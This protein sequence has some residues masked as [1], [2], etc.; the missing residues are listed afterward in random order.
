MSASAK[1]AVIVLSAIVFIASLG[2]LVWLRRSIA[3]ID[4]KIAQSAAHRVALESSLA[5]GKA[6]L[7]S[8]ERSL[9]QAAQSATAPRAEGA[10]ANRRAAFNLWE[11]LE[12][13]PK[14]M[15]LYLRDFRAN[16]LD[17]FGPL[18]VQ[19]TITPEQISKWEDLATA[20]E[21]ENIDLRAAAA[22]QGLPADD[23]GIAA[24][25]R[26][27]N[28]Q[29]REASIAIVGEGV[30]QQVQSY[31]APPNGMVQFIN[32]MAASAAQNG[33]PINFQQLGQIQSVFASNFT[34]NG[35]GGNLDWQKISDQASATLTG[36][37]LQTVQAMV[38]I[39]QLSTQV[40]QYFAAQGSGQ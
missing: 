5:R 20:H 29:F 36:T 7:D 23:P 16:L 22:E 18:M 26:Q 8:T 4:R 10:P 13:D 30:L 11:T 3:E 35:A 2:W 33:A 37:Q 24:M 19:L 1:K 38:G 34:P 15:Q 6:H 31:K 32:Q 25:R 39:A 27:S 14:L 21:Q 28:E 9:A 40:K 12:S 17:R